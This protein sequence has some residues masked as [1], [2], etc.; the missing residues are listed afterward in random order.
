MAIRDVAGNC[1]NGTMPAM[2]MHDQERERGGEVGH[3]LDAFA[4]DRVG[5]D[6]VANEPVEA[7]GGEL[8]LAGNDAGA[9]DGEVEEQPDRER[10]QHDDQHRLGD[11]A[12]ERRELEVG[13]PGHVELLRRHGGDIQAL[14]GSLL[15]TRCFVT[16]G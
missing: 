4:A 9:A 11:P 13:G 7:L 16:R 15:S 1:A 8:Q 14:T 5:G 10:A 2:F 6:R 12:D 3:V